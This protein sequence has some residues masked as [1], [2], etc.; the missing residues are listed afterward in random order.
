M[1]GRVSGKRRVQGYTFLGVRELRSLTMVGAHEAR[2]V[3][4]HI[5][6]GVQSLKRQ[7]RAE[8]KIQSRINNP[9]RYVKC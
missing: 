9:T 1:P 2:G 8:L 7:N 5:V 4:M 3:R 6:K